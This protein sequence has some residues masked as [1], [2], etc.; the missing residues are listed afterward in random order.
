M[1]A[2]GYLFIPVF[3]IGNTRYRMRMRF[4]SLRWKPKKVTDVFEKGTVVRVWLPP[5]VLI[6]TMMDW[7]E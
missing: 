4:I 7:R 2:H 1:T 3:Y 6:T 5:G